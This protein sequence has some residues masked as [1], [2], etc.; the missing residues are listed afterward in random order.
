[1]VFID[2]ISRLKSSI[3]RH[4]VALAV[5]AAA[6]IISWLLLSRELISQ[7]PRFT[8]YVVSD[9]IYMSSPISGTVIS[10]CVKRGQRVETGTPLFNIDLTSLAAR[11]EKIKAQIQ[12][13]ESQRQIR[14]AELTAAEAASK[15]ANADLNRLLSAQAEIEGTVSKK[16]IDK[17]SETV[18]KT[19]ADVLS[20][21]N[22]IAAA[23]SQIDS[24][25]AELRDIEHQITELSPKSPVSG[26]IEETMFKPGEWAAANAAIVSI[27]P[28]DEIKVRFYVPQNQIHNYPVGTKVAIAYDG[29]P[30]GM[31]ATVDFVSTRP[32]YTPP[33]IYSIET[34]DKLVFMVEAVPADPT[35]LIPGQPIDVRPI[36][37]KGN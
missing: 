37:D 6:G 27:V 26:R 20:A 8:G 24:S 32:E 5:I 35:K 10:V 36:A 15:L 3:L 11:T 14:Q 9:N 34:R 21:Q 16:D 13:A 30:K 28:D 18:T 22:Q 29:G 23:K 19:K 2:I 33:I 17:A 12:E 1:M 25:K 7:L 31:T 4:K